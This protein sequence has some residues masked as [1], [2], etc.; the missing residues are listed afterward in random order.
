M[1]DAQLRAI[2]AHLAKHGLWDKQVPLRKDVDLKLPQFLGTNIEEH[3]RNIANNQIKDYKALAERLCRYELPQQPPEWAELPG[4]VR[5]GEDGVPEPVDYPQ[6]DVLVFDVEILVTEGNYPTMATAVSD[7]HWFSWCSDYLVS[8]KFRWAS[9]GI[10]LD[11]LIPV[12]TGPR[13]EVNGSSESRLRILYKAAET[14]STTKV[15]LEYKQKRKER[16]TLTTDDWKNQSSLNNLGDVHAL[17]VGGTKLD[18]DPRDIFIEGSMADVRD[19]FQ[20]STMAVFLVSLSILDIIGLFT[21]PF[22]QMLHCWILNDNSAHFTLGCKMVQCTYTFVVISTQW[23]VFL[24]CLDRASRL[25]FPTSQL[26]TKQRAAWIVVCVVLLSAFLSFHYLLYEDAHLSEKQIIYRLCNGDSPAG[27]AVPH[28]VPTD[29]FNWGLTNKLM[30]CFFPVTLAWA[31]MIATQ[32][33]LKVFKKRQQSAQ[34]EVVRTM[35]EEDK[36]AIKHS[37]MVTTDIIWNLRF[38]H[39]VTLAGMFEM[40]TGYLPVNE[41]WERYINQSNT[42]YEDMQNQYKAD[43]WLWD[44]DWTVKPF[45]IKKPKPFTK[46]QKQAIEDKKLFDGDAGNQEKSCIEEVLA[47]QERH[48]KVGNRL[49]GYPEWYKDLC[50]KPTDEDWSPGPSGL[51]PQTRVTPKLLRLTWDGFPLHYDD[52]HGWGY[53]VPGRHDN[54]VTDEENKALLEGKQLPKERMFPYRHVVM[55]ELCKIL[56]FQPENINE[57]EDDTDESPQSSGPIEDLNSS[58]DSVWAV[59]DLADLAPGVASD[60]VW[61][62][63][64]L[65]D[66]SPR[67]TSDTVWAYDDVSDK[68]GDEFRMGKLIQGLEKNPRDKFQK[69]MDLQEPPKRDGAEKRVG[70]PLAK[71]YLMHMEDGTLSTLSGPGANMVLRLAKTCSYWKNNQK[72]IEGQ[73]AVWLKDEELPHEILRSEDYVE[74]SS[75]GAIVP[76]IIPAG[77]VTRRGVESTW[78]TASN[79]Y[80]DRIGRCTALGWMTLQGT[81]KDGTDLHSRVADTVGISRDHAKVFNYGRIYGAGQTFA[82]KL[83]MQFNHRL[84]RAEAKDKAQLMFSTTKGKRSKRGWIGGSES[85]MFNK[86][87]AIAQS[88][89]PQTPVLGC[90]ISKSLEPDTVFGEFMTSR[91]NWVVQ[92]SAVDYLH[93]ML[94]SMQWL[95]EEYGING[96]FAISIHDESVAFFSAVDIDR[97]LRKEVVM[98]CV[99]PSNPHGLH[100]GYQIPMGEALDIHEIIEKTGGTLERPENTIPTQ[101]EQE[102][103]LEKVFK[104]ITWR[105]CSRAYSGYSVQ[106]QILEKTLEKVFMGKPWRKCSRAYLGERV[107]G[108]TLENVLRAYPGESVQGQTLEKVFKGIPWRKCSRVNLGES[109]QGHTQEKVFNGIPRRKCSRAYP[110]ES[111]EGQTLEKVFKGRPWRKCYP[112]GSVQGQTLEKT[113]EKVFKG[114]PC[115]KCSRAYLGERVQGHTL[116][117]VFKGRP[118]RKCSR[119]D[120]GESVT[121]EEVFKGR[122]WR[123][124]YPGES[125]QGQTLEKALKKVFKGKPWRKCSWADPGESVQ[126]QTLEKVFKGRPW[127]K[128]SWANPGESVP[129]HTLEKEFKGIPWR[130]CSRAYPRESVQGQ[131][132]EKVCKGKPWR[133]CSR[134]YP[135]ESVQGH[136]QEKVFQGQTLEKVFKRIS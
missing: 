104:G 23:I 70:N 68:A 96:R 73:M 50:Q 108:H 69:L 93:L 74:G 130:M 53:L 59:N 100:M 20:T 7:K 13:S 127:R 117:K 124:F 131:T 135:G 16:N 33:M 42:V 39:P 87:E 4:W 15:V 5:Y 86:L 44:L 122:P 98:D 65:A 64:D 85:A 40:L 43:P 116:E 114:K 80:T 112:G 126:G 99:T 92:S 63:N 97:C 46:K 41:N 119:A 29:T 94:V 129:G 133:K 134:A 91:I 77:T 95:F 21:E 58:A 47:L 88:G 61:A 10:G 26:I 52:T 34:L 12:E 103:T 123:K 54:L 38:P 18:K 90:H 49:V 107:Q 71:D 30:S 1:S 3:F 35:S 28:D 113:L 67:N 25:C 81:K 45:R 37:Y 110:G 82:E 60:S 8:D 128:C 66:P 36:N 55:K 106:G 84:T 31:C 17:H 111:V 11:D 102:Q 19:N 109:V 32:Q 76:R 78:L 62:V 101:A 83:L 24:V 14:E 118:W 6:D 22:F 132:L 57:Q 125:V 51:S 120:P 79:A 115:R 27:I 136:T 2:K 121:L 75:L 72:R 48:F 9:K 89:Y 105:K 56:N